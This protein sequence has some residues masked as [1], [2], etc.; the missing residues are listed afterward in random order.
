MLKSILGTDGIRGE[1]IPA[2]SP[3]NH[4]KIGIRATS[5]ACDFL[6]KESNYE[7]IERIPGYPAIC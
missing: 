2:L 4:D 5:I 6:G 7:V 1:V 3:R